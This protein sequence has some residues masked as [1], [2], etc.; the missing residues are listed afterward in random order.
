[1]SVLDVI[2]ACCLV[3]GA[4]SCLLGAVGL[5]TF[6][7][8]TA[9]LQA[10][11]KPQTLGLILVLIGT[12]LQLDFHYSLALALVA[13][14]QMLTAPVLAQLVGRAAYRADSIRRE[15][16]VVDEMGERIEREHDRP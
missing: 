1:M 12:A 9:R 2:S 3:L 8:V 6:P 10:A 13:L 7:D 11:T 15:N 14:F 16:L 4:L 5:L